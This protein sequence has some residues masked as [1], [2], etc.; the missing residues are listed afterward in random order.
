MNTRLFPS[1]VIKPCF[2]LGLQ[3]I[4]LGVPNKASAIKNILKRGHQFRTTVG[5]EMH[6]N[7]NVSAD[8]IC[9]ITVQT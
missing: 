8:I 6:N 2:R 3:R 1:Y 9:K 5:L 7:N 4:G